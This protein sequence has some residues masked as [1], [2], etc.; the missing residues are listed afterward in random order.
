MAAC[1]ANVSG[2][3]SQEGTLRG[4][5]G[6]TGSRNVQINP[7]GLAQN[8][9]ELLTLNPSD[10]Y[11]STRQLEGTAGG[12]AK[13]IVKD[14]IVLD[15]TVNPD[16][17]DVESD[18]PQFTVNQRFPV[19]FPEL[20]PFFLE[21][22]NY[23]ST[24]ITLLYTRRIVR[25]EFGARLTGK[26]NHTNIGLLAI[27][28]RQPA[29]T[30]GSDDPCDG[31]RAG[32]FV[33]RVSE[34][35]GKNSSVG[36]IYTDEEFAGGWNRVGGVDFNFRLNNKW[37]TLGQFVESS[38]NGSHDGSHDGIAAAVF[39]A[40]YK[41]GPATDL[42]VYR[43]GHAWNLQGEYQDLARGFL[44]T[45]GLSRPRTFARPY[46]LDLPVVSEA[47]CGAELRAGRQSEPGVRPCRKPCVS[48]FSV[49]S[50]SAAAAQPR[51]GADHG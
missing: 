19:Y 36:L 18:Q 44:A 42:Q 2:T 38:T 10:P 29:Q 25:P 40:G 20:R 23:F 39:P 31:K 50:I 32:F 12:E 5:E 1:L 4:I 21:N 33:G 26:V 6:V 46:S 45:S 8:E 41:A 14:S 37:T 15:G 49:R 24:P 7:Y 3:L 28:D 11:F 35:V 22:A 13:V 16:F 27:D 34:D 30:V 17:S 9:H 43:S 51:A 48:V 47:Q